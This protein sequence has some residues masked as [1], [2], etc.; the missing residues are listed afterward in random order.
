MKKDNWIIG[1]VLGAGLLS[2]VAAGAASAYPDDSWDFGGGP[3][4]FARGHMMEG[5]GRMHGLLRG[6]DLT[7][8]QRD[9][10]FK[11]FHEQMPT[12]HD[13]MKALRAGR[14]QLREAAMTA[15]YDPGKVRELAD[16]QGK[17]MADLI[18]LRTESFNKVYALL[19]P[20]QQ[21]KVSEWRGHGWRERRHEGREAR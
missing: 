13:K 9:A 2:L 15:T 11:I 7:D 19:T 17:L 1:T 18:V 16:A 6:L 14:E 12:V 20:E 21:K 4:A 10:V 5:P 8:E 3:H